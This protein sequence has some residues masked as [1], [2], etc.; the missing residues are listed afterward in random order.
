[1]V[2]LFRAAQKFDIIVNRIQIFA[3]E[4]G[5]VAFASFNITGQ[6]KISLIEADQSFI[7][8]PAFFNILLS[9]KEFKDLHDVQH[10]HMHAGHVLP[11]I[12]ASHRFD[13]LCQDRILVTQHFAESADQG[14][15]SIFRIRMSIASP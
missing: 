8:M 13:G 4:G 9:G 12:R 7:V 6:E 5:L 1:M 2:E 3:V 11:K 14:F 10:I 15:Q